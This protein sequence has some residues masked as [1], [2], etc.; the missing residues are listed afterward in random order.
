MKTITNQL[1]EQ[2]KTYLTEFEKENIL[3]ANG[4]VADIDGGSTVFK[5]NWLTSALDGENDWSAPV[6]IVLEYK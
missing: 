3:T 5:D 2:F 4:F 6:E 1:T